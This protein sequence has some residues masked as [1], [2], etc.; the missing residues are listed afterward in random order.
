MSVTAKQNY[1][2][3][4]SRMLITTFCLVKLSCNSYLKNVPNNDLINLLTRCTDFVSKF[5][6]HYNSFSSYNIQNVINII[7]IHDK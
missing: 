5:K 4:D 2:Q 6:T 7:M 1:V 3:G